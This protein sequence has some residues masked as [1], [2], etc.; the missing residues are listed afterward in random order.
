MCLFVSHYREICECSVYNGDNKNNSKENEYI[1]K[2][3]NK[4]SFRKMATKKKEKQ[5]KKRKK[6]HEN[7]IKTIC[8]MKINF[9]FFFVFSSPFQICDT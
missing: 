1:G 4:F 5:R 3:S 6:S 2:M 9:E 8:E 7:L